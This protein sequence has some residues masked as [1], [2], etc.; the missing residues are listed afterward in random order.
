MNTRET[1]FLSAF[2]LLITSGQISFA[3]TANTGQNR[4]GTGM[5]RL[6]TSEPERVKLDNLRFNIAP[7]E[8][9]KAAPKE[10]V[11]P[12]AEPPVRWRIDGVSNRPNRPAGQRI[13]IW[14]DGQVYAESELPQG[15]SLVRNAQGEITGLNSAVSKGKIEF[16]RI[17]DLIT[18]P[19]TAEEGKAIEL[20]EQKKLQKTAAIS[21][22]KP[23]EKPQGNL[24]DKLKDKLSLKP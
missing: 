15:L 3:Q 11:A 9:A 8:L 4:Y 6:L 1:T 22:E 10:E 7:P 18:R 16:S 14:I 21:A 13:S 23:E 24:L 17:G 2:L 20:A 5:G 19:Q 12:I